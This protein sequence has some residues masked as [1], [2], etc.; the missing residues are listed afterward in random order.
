MPTG[1]DTQDTMKRTYYI[2]AAKPLLAKAVTA[3]VLTVAGL[4][5]VTAQNSNA[6]RHHE[7]IKRQ[8]E[9]ADSLRLQMR[10]AADQ[11]R[12]LLWGDSILR[13]RLSKGDIDSAKYS[14]LQARL[15][16][17]DRKL[18]KGDI[19]LQQKYN[20]VNY[21]TL[22]ISRPRERWVIK[23]RGNLSGASIQYEGKN[24]ETPFKGNLKA[25][26]RGT[27]SIAVAYR[28]I[29]AGIAINPAKLAGKSKDNEFNL[30]SYGNAFG[31]D[32]IYL[33]S[34]TY[35]GKVTKGDVTHY[36][37]KGQVKQQAV[38]INAYYA[39]NNKRFSFPAAFSQSYLQKRSA[40]S[41]MVGMSFDGQQTD[42]TDYGEGGGPSRMRV[43]ELGIGAGYGYNLVLGRHWLFHLSALP[44][45]AVLVKSKVTSDTY[46][47]SYGYK[48]PSVI[49][50]GR[51]AAV[52]SWKNKFAGLTMVYNA[53]T[54]GT[55]SILYLDREKGRI[56]LFYG[57]RF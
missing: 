23:L 45:F 40:G 24:N 31:F 41:F 56:R 6:H 50:T 8:L 7:R 49:I 29:A 9:T 35:H 15:H 52:Y 20:K 38:N 25:D 33:S 3:V 30:N 43:V 37:D 42:A 26:Y 39:F 12:L 22:Y 5:T 17:A 19:M 1:P 53:S 32:V 48:F 28:G 54:T 2:F 34:K 47:V 16:K 46:E 21:D 55:R 10:K 57:F 13:A 11:G 18:H 27:L 44:T 36:I 51:G 14:R 4:C